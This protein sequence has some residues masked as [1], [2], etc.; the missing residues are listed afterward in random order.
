MLTRK[1]ITLKKYILTIKK[2]NTI[3]CANRPTTH[4]Q[5]NKATTTATLLTKPLSPNSLK[6]RNKC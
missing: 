3:L 6:E 4:A 2:E 5:K 1:T